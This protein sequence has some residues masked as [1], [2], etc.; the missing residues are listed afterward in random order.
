MI[1][2]TGYCEFMGKRLERTEPRQHHYHLAV[3]LVQPVKSFAHLG[4][5]PKKLFPLSVVFEDWFSVIAEEA[6][7]EDLRLPYQGNSKYGNA[8]CLWYSR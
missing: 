5:N 3:S 4:E 2:V 6:D 8:P 1:I 7:Y